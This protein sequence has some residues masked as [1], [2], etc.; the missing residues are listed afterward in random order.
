MRKALSFAL[1]SL[2]L[3]LFAS[4]SNA[5]SND[6]AGITPLTSVRV[7]AGLASPL[8]VTTPPGDLD[9]LFIVQQRGLIRILNLATGGVNATPFINLST[10]VSSSGSERGLLGL[11][12]HPDYA[13]NGFFYVSYTRA[14]GHASIVE[15]YTVSGDPNVADAASATTIFGP[16]SQPF[17]NHNGGCI[18]FGP[19]GKLYLGLGDGG[20][21]NDPSCNAQNGNSLLGKLLRLNDDGSVPVDNPFVGVAGFRD[22][23]WAY[24]LRNPW[25]F[26]FDRA[27]GDL[28]IGDVGQNAIE[29]IDWVP[30]GSL[31]G[32]NYGW[33]VMEGN[34]CFSTSACT[35]PPPCNDPSFTDPIHTYSHAGGNCSVSGGYVYRG[36][37]IPSLQGTYFFADF[38]ST[39]IWS[40]EWD[41]VSQSNFQTR[42]AE[43]TPDVGSIGN[44][45][46]FGEDGYGELY[47]VDLGGELFKIVAV[48]GDC[49]GN[50]IADGCEGSSS[51]S[52]NGL[53][54]N[55]AGFVELTPPVLGASWDTTVDI[56]TPG[57]LG[58]IVSISTGGPTSGIMLSGTIAGELLCLPPV[59]ALDVSTG[60]HSIPIPAD[61]TLIG[62]TLCAQ[63]STFV[64]GQV[65]LN[66]AIDITLGSF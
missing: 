63:G 49:N 42:Q 55:P 48:D 47:I 30:A 61:C 14:S 65:T 41:G 40:F 35:A 25:R 21:A 27:N 11:A 6:A 45:A 28:W 56:V 43:L 19:D 12:F 1:A 18:Q 57:A 3:A 53:G 62:R 29:E 38:C 23:I 34:N 2:G 50:N 9:R 15:R 37:G 20:S 52:R 58:S 59:V 8:Y 46:S 31:G 64:I 54:G 26:S 33:K 24:G 5:L 17:S 51:T 16:Q 10:K 44:I 39:R 7:A 13:S 22:E 32:E 36:C 60:S 66:N 4:P